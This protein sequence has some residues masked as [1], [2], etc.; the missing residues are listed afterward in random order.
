MDRTEIRE[1]EARRALKKAKSG[2]T[3]GIDEV[4]AELYKA[5]S[6]V[7]VKELTRLTRLFNRGYL[8]NRRKA[9]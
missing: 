6:D 4:P 3:P 5:A 1:A 8:T 9:S 7:A 2:K